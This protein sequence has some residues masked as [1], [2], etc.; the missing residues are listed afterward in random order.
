MSEHNTGKNVG[1][2]PAEVNSSC[3]QTSE[4]PQCS[5]SDDPSFEPVAPSDLE[6]P[7]G[8]EGD[9]GT[10]CSASAVVDSAKAAEEKAAAENAAA[11]NAA[12]IALKAAERE[13]RRVARSAS[14][15]ALKVSTIDSKQKLCGVLIPVFSLRREG[16]LGI[17]DTQAVRDAVEFCARNNMAVLQVL[18]INETSGDNS[19]YNAISSAAL[20]PALCAVSPQNIPGL[21]EDDYKRIVEESRLSE[22]DQDSVHYPMVKRLKLDLLRAAWKNFRLELSSPDEQVR[23]FQQFQKDEIEWL[24]PYT[25]YRALI[26]VHDGNGCWTQWE[27]ALQNYESA[28]EWLNASVDKEKLEDDRQFRAFVQWLAFKQWRE[29][30]LFADAR[31][32]KLMGDIPFGVSRFSADVWHERELFDLEWSGGAPPEPFFQA[33]EFTRKWGQNW[34]IPLYKWAAH[35]ESN[36]RWWRQ[37]VRCLTD[38]FHYFRID[39]VLGFFRMYS[40]PWIPERNA[41][42]VNLAEEEAAVLTKGRLPQ[43]LPRADEPEENADLNEDDGEALLLMIMEASGKNGVVAEDLGMVPDYVRPLLHE[44]GIPGF[45]I[46]IF[47]RHEEDRS[48]KSKDE[49]HPIS[50]VTYGT[51]DHWPLAMFYDDLVAR[52]HGPDGHEAWLDVQRLMRFLELEEEDPP[53]EFTDELHAAFMR[54]LLETHCWLAVN[55]ISDLLGTREQFNAP[56]VSSGLNWSRRLEMTL[57]EFEKDARYSG[58][59]SMLSD[60]I[61]ETGRLAHERATGTIR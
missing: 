32:V 51:H 22:L 56:G 47:E 1:A 12:E 46:P 33:D 21:N 42:F 11:E 52:W 28:L 18:P 5:T 24:P 41:E 23:A 3:G 14:R 34:G 30:R 7:A 4:S 60:L 53:I 2:L 40:F 25:L 8:K 48:F 27:P 57:P 38:V 55:M 49:L 43:F 16:D 29:L 58:K 35:K 45:A 9:V 13:R 37:R 20:E 39:H 15:A 44:L 50:L 26:D 54:T 17:G 10:G 59:I 61:K 6:K 31:G 36:Y 19:P